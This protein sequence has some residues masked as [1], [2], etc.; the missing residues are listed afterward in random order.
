MNGLGD[1][2]G[3]AL[4]RVGV[5]EERVSKWLGKP[6][7]CRRRKRKLNRLSKWVEQQLGATV[8]EAREMLG[9]IVG[10]PF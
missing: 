4:N 8:E 3:E 5:T 7:G 2:I 10:K 1:V 9:T 6:C